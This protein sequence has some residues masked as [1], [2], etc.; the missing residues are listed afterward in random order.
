MRTVLL[1]RTLGFVLLIVGFSLPAASAQTSLLN[2]QSI[3]RK[4]GFIFA[5]VVVSVERAPATSGAI[6]SMR[7]SF[8]VDRALRGVHVG[9]ILTLNQWS[10]LWVN[11]GGRYRVGER[12]VVFLHPRSRA[13]L[14][15]A[16]GGR[17]GQFEMDLQGNVV[18][19]PDQI[20]LFTPTSEAPLA[21]G[22]ARTSL[23]ISPAQ[24]RAVMAW[25]D[26]AR[27]VRLAATQP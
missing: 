2:L 17:L 26:F 8:R 24:S 9:Q 4:A 23:S 13:G 22:K 10:G 5:G 27:A 25:D 21:T 15:S 11:G 16:V 7:I 19:R 20:A 14:T 12:L 1:Q 3:T 18:L 6:G